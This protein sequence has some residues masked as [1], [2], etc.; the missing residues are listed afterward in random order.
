D[1]KE[2]AAALNRLN[3]IYPE[4]QELHKRLG[5]LLLAQNNVSGA[6]REYQAWVALKPLDQA[7]AHYELANALKS[8]N[9]IEEARDQVLQSLEAAPGYKPAQKLLLEISK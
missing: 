9:R 3:Y 6:I 1:K 4:D 2:A 7:S 8:A 5:D